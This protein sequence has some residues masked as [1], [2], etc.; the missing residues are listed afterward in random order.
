MK[1]LKNLCILAL[2]SLFLLGMTVAVSGQI[3]YVDAEAIGA[4]DGSSWADAYNFLQDALAVAVGGDEIWVAEGIYKPDQG[5]GITPSD[6]MATF[7]LKNGVA[8]YGGF[9]GGETILEQRDWEANETILSGD[10]GTPGNDK[11]NSFHVVVGSGTD[12]TAVLDG[13]TITAGNADG[14]GYP[15]FMGAGMLNHLGSPSVT[16]CLFWGNFASTGGGMFNRDSNAMITNCSFIGNSV[17]G[18][19]GGMG[20]DNWV[21]YSNR[22]TI[23]NCSFIGNWA[24]GK[25][26]AL[27][28]TICSTRLINCIF[29]GNSAGKWGGVMFN[30]GTMAPRMTNCIFIGNSAAERGGVM[31]SYPNCIPKVTNCILWDNTAPIGAQID[32]YL[33]PPQVEYSIVQ[34]GWAGEGNI[35]T[36]PCFVQPGYWDANGG[37]IEGDYHLA[38]NSPCIDTG[39]ND[40]LDLP[41]YDAE[42]NPRI[43]DGDHD[44]EPVVDMGSYE[45]QGI[46]EVN[47]DIKPG[48]FPNSINLGSN[49]NV[50][51]AIFSTLDFDATTVDP[52][53]VTLAGATVKVKGRGTPMASEDDID[54]DGLIDLVVHVDTTALELTGSDTDAILEG[55]TYDGVRIRGTDTVRIVQD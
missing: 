2:A 55:Q 25:G 32:Y 50:P 17:L 29:S 31:H 41:V 27:E 5:F 10:I 26:G 47:I 16:N 33:Q 37:W 19:G 30:Q 13:F 34:G 7:Q 11:D 18:D 23:I 39:T 1:E 24:G 20:S 45:Y 46:V 36:D 22:P 54:G 40:A 52:E 28:N 49:G 8:I 21:S 48:S 43:A 9:V 53:T 4:N 12:N 35:D 14:E 51:V 44:G 3:V 42:G 6:R 38:Q 15:N